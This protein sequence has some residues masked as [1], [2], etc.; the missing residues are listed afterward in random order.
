[1]KGAKLRIL[2]AGRGLVTAI[3]TLDRLGIHRETPATAGPWGQAG[4]G[5]AA[6]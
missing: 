4:W 6:G 2:S 3:P 1:M 5:Q